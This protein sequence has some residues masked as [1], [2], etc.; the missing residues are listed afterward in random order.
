MADIFDEIGEELRAERAGKLFARYSWVLVA[1]AVLIVA[2]V[3]AWQWR[4]DQ[5]RHRA[6][7]AAGIF[8]AASREATAA[9]PGGVETSSRKDAAA[10]LGRLAVS[11]PESYRTLARL[12]L[13]AVQA[14]TDPAV[15][16]E[17]WDAVA[18]DPQADP[19]L[20]GLATLLWAQHQLNGGDAATIEARLRP[21]ADASGPWQALAQEQLAWLDL[22]R[23]DD[24]KAR[25]LFRS[26]SSDPLAPQGVRVRTTGLLAQLGETAPAA[27]ATTPVAAPSSR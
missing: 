2:A 5:S 16:S 4:R 20:R 8:L 13:A 23:G 7:V 17:A 21:L 14:G 12:R 3:G 24:T 26:L 10:S 18:A 1:A 15:A 9:A 27:T 22:R 11:A 25:D 19:L 6:E